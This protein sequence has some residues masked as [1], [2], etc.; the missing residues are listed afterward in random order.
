[1]AGVMY[2]L[3]ALFRLQVT[4]PHIGS[5]LEARVTQGISLC[6]STIQD[7]LMFNHHPRGITRPVKL[8]LQVLKTVLRGGLVPELMAIAPNRVECA[9]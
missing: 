3:G 7:V 6:V 1:M 2:H 5:H 9:V 4:G 8:K